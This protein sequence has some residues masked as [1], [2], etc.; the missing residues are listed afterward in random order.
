LFG[1]L[2]NPPYSVP[3]RPN[4]FHANVLHFWILISSLSHYSGT[5][6]TRVSAGAGSKNDLDAAGHSIEENADSDLEESI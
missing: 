4:Q 2:P 5:H 6:L 1:Y 3:F